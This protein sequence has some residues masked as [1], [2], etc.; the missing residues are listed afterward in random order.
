MEA[1]KYIDIIIGIIFCVCYA[2]QT[3][4]IPVAWTFRRKYTK[5]AKRNTFAVLIC[6]RNESAVIGD[7]I[8]SIKEQTYDQSLITTFVMADNCTDNTAD[9]AKAHGAVVY[10]RFN[11]ELVGKGY[12]LSELLGHIHEDHPEGFDAYIIFDADNILKKDYFEKMNL[13][14][15]QGHDIITSY[16]NSKNYGDNWISAGYGLWFLRE[17]RY[18]NHARYLLHSSCAVSGTG[19]LFSRKIEEEVRDWPFHLLTEDLEFTAYNITKGRKI[20]F[21]KEAEFFDEQPV[22]F[23]QSWRQRKR[24]AK[25]NFQVFGKYGLDLTKGFMRGNFACF[26]FA[27]SIMPAFVLTLV[28]IAVNLFALVYSIVAN[29]GA[30]EFVRMAGNV[31]SSL[32]GTMVLMGAITTVTEWKHI[33]AS[34]FKKILYVF[35]FPIFMATYIPISVAALF[36]N[37]GWKPIEHTKSV[38]AIA[39]SEKTGKRKERKLRVIFAAAAVAAVAI[40]SF[41]SG[42]VSNIGAKRIVTEVQA[43]ELEDVDYIVIFTAETG[44]A[45]TCESIFSDRLKTACK[46]AGAGKNTK[47]IIIDERSESEKKHA[48]KSLY[49]KNVTDN[50]EIV[51]SNIDYTMDKQSE[52][53]YESLRKLEEEYSAKKVIIV[54]QKCHL[55]RALYIAN[56]I[57]IDAYGVASDE[58]TE[59]SGEAIRE[60]SEA[61][62]RIRDFT[63]TV[64]DGIFES[65]EKKG[66]DVASTK[67]GFDSMDGVFKNPKKQNKDK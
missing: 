54:T 67:G 33:N 31:L 65:S 22:K 21:C 49:I 30:V 61:F 28:A 39:S 14:L 55:S 20:A 3:F 19:F 42:Y 62:A 32:Y 13:C 36:G 51:L 1:I 6:G 7:L 58:D 11:K 66:K 63:Y 37:C 9:V 50:S 46:F 4:Y 8:E 25:G 23:S 40:L 53:T 5:E 44:D 26:D 60:V 45:K 43:S 48:K 17:S 12:A 41:I 24:W 52:S 38:K 29:K 57:G 2:Y 27:V 18:L 64:I 35:T 47:L 34:V 16:R 10:K 56:K 59:Y 15:S